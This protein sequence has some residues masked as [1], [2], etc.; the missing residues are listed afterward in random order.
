MRGNTVKRFTPILKNERR[1][2]DPKIIRKTPVFRGAQ[3]RRF[4][5]N[6]DPLG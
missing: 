3:G 5:T 6:P 1:I 2:K 4:M